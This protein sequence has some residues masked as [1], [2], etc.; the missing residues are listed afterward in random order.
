M[1]KTPHRSAWA[2]VYFILFFLQ[3]FAKKSNVLLRCQWKHRRGEC[4]ISC[5][6]LVYLF[7]SLCCRCGTHSLLARHFDKCWH[8]LCWL[9]STHWGEGQTSS[10]LLTRWESTTSA[11]SPPWAHCPTAVF[12]LCCWKCL[13]WLRLT[14]KWAD[15]A[16]TQSL[17][18]VRP[19][20]SAV[21]TSRPS[22]QGGEQFFFSLSSY[23]R[24]TGTTHLRCLGVL[25]C[26]RFFWTVLASGETPREKV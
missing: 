9:V 17:F 4:G 19:G 5:W 11:P 18:D 23:L 10:C 2:N 26:L 3:N 14:S 6:I 15:S 8:L 16:E 1:A 25:R 24:C 13:S 21:L 22:L 20:Y 7:S 12:V